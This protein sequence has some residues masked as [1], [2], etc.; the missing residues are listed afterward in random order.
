MKKKTIRFGI[1]ILI[2]I[3][4]AIFIRGI[5]GN[6]SRA[7]EI[8]IAEAESVA[9]SDDSQE[10]V[11]ESTPEDVID[12]N[13]AICP[14]MGGE[15][16]EGQYVEWEGYRVHFCCAGCDSRFLA[17]PEKYLPVLAQESAVAELLGIECANCYPEE[18]GCDQP[19]PPYGGGCH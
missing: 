13:N 1:A 8:E 6:E 14:V 18:C 4:A 17:D 19:E 3:V 16:M 12:L 5:S 15:V 7:D 9:V 2:G 10:Q 11:D